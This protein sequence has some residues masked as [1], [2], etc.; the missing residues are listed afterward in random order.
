VRGYLIHPDGSGFEQRQPRVAADRWLV[1]QAALAEL[2]EFRKANLPVAGPGLYLVT[3]GRGRSG[4]RIPEW[5]PVIPE[6]PGHDVRA[7]RSRKPITVT[8]RDLLETAR[9][10]ERR[11]R[12]LNLKP[13]NWKQRL[14]DVAL[15]TVTP[16]GRLTD[17]A[18]VGTLTIDGMFHRVGMVG[19][20]KSALMQG[21]GVVLTWPFY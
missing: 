6:H 10:T 18:E 15:T 12:G 1:Y 9:W 3:A 16:D 5:L 17:R 21:P 4:V 11:E 19:V 8:R 20:G 7:V 13:G 2:P 14:N